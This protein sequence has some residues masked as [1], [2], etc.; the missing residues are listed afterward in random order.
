MKLI[1]F[2]PPGEE[3]PGVWIEATQHSEA[4]ILDVR[5]CAFDIEDYT[6]SFFRNWGLA[7][8][9][10]LFVEKKSRRVP[11][12][13]VRLAPPIPASG[14][15]VCLGKNY[16]AHAEEFDAAIP[17]APVF[18]SKAR[19]AI[20][21]AHDPIVLPAGARTI[22]AEVELAVVLGSD[23]RGATPE[24]AED[25]VAGYTILNDVTD[26]D[27]QRERGQWFFGKNADTFCPIGPWL[28]TADEIPRPVDLRLRQRLNGRVLQDARTSNMIFGIGRALSELSQRMTLEAGDIVSM[29]TPA[30]IGSAQ[31]PTRVLAPGDIVECEIERIGVLSNPVVAAS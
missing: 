28:V 7:R 29:G 27:A 20:V 30:G 25:A 16:A 3:R 24:E 23:I 13:D 12:N 21:G 8:L 1:R 5:A 19:T 22:D 17:S 14:K 11:A 18:F 26:R 4:C 6:P 2:G 10:R 31:T 15:I 9:H